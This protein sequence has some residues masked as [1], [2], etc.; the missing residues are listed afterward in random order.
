MADF[1]KA[2]RQGLEAYEDAE[3]A[4]KEIFGLFDEFAEQVEQASTGR[5]RIKRD[6]G[7]EDTVDA[8]SSYGMVEFGK[9]MVPVARVRTREYEA[10]V[11]LG[12]PGEAREE[13]CEYELGERG[14]PVTLRYAREDV[15]CHDGEAL[16][17]GLQKLL[18][19]PETG[20]KLQ[21]LMGT[22]QAA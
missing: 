7:T 18:A 17:R 20:G 15:R 21:R 4:R 19:H 13:L 5:V 12:S 22:E 6:K 2:F 9:P 14:Y 10:I 3:R 16:E 8:P 11:A 1:Q